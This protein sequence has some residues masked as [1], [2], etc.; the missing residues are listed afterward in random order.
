MAFRDELAVAAAFAVGRGPRVADRSMPDRVQGL[1]WMPAVGAL[2]GLAAALVAAAAGAIASAPVA[3]LGAVAV[4]RW[5]G[6]GAAGA[7]VEI[8]AGLVQW[9]AVLTLAPAARTVALVAAPM[10]ACWASVVQC[11]GG[12][13]LPG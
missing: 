12:T 8:V 1:A 4:L 3:A 11:Y 13:A 10:L 9:L 7:L 2:V 6:G 5:A